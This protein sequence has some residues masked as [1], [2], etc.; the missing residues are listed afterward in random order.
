[1]A[2]I[3]ALKAAES[4]AAAPLAMHLA[5]Q[6]ARVQAFLNPLTDRGPELNRRSFPSKVEP[7]TNR[8]DSTK[9]FPPKNR[10][11]FFLK[12][13]GKLPLNLGNP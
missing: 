1:M 2:A 6:F 7:R 8:Q 4:P 13:A 11:P 3:G 5:V 10:P 9:E 12:L